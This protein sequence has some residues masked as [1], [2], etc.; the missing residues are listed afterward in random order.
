MACHH[1]NIVHASSLS[2][3]MT[4]LFACILYHSMQSSTDFFCTASL[5]RWPASSFLYLKKISNPSLSPTNPPALP[6][7]PS[8]GGKK[9]VGHKRSRIAKCSLRWLRQGPKD[10]RCKRLFLVQGAL[11]SRRSHFLRGP[12]TITIPL[13]RMRK[14]GS[15]RLGQRRNTTCYSKAVCLRKDKWWVFW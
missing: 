1:C 12:P 7:N 3:T 13:P 2:V 5:Y 4:S 6:A 10:A 8:R 15:R 11:W 14:C 9:T